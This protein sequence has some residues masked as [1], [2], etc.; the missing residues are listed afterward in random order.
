MPEVAY[1]VA[2]D[3]LRRVWETSQERGEC[4]AW[5]RQSRSK[6]PQVAFWKARVSTRELRAF[7]EESSGFCFETIVLLFAYGALRRRASPE[8]EAD[9]TRTTME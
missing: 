3:K 1:R 2:Q 5:V 4:Q 7:G 9:K 8:K 6:E